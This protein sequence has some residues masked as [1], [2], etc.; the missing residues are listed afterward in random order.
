MLL[1]SNLVFSRVNL[2]PKTSVVDILVVRLQEYNLLCLS[3]TRG[4]KGLRQE[5]KQ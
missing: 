3:K 4:K 2:L 1:L 5:D